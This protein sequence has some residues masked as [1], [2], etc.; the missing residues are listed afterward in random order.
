MFRHTGDKLEFVK[1]RL[2]SE[3]LFFPL[4]GEAFPICLEQKR[5]KRPWEDRECVRLLRCCE[6]GDDL[7][8]VVCNG[9]SLKESER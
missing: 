4:G 5:I 9:A 3:M 2:I 7:S 6:K 8:W 1:M